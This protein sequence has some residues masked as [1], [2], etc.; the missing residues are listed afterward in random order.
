MGWVTKALNEVPL[1]L[2]VEG[3]KLVHYKHMNFRGEATNFC[4]VSWVCF[5]NEKRNQR[6][7]GLER[8]E[9]FT[10]VTGRLQ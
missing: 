4:K 1:S 8:V 6:R 3:I 7:L 10:V 9:L 2:W 5:E